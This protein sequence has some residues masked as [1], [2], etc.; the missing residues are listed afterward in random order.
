MNNI[1]PWQTAQWQQLMSQRQQHKLPHALLLSGVAGL[2]KHQFAEHFAESLLCHNNNE[3]GMA[4]GECRGCLLL[5]AGSHPDIKRIEPE[6][7]G[8]AIKVD[9]VRAL[10]N[11]T[12]LSAQFDK[13]YKVVLISPAENMNRAAA[14]SLLKTLEGPADN[15]ILILLTSAPQRLLATIRSRCQRIS[16]VAPHHDV[17]TEWLTAQSITNTQQWLEMADGAP[18]AAF[19]LANNDDNSISAR[20]ES[21]LEL[22]EGLQSRRQDP[23]AMAADWQKKEG[24]RAVKWLTNWVMDIIRLSQGGDTATLACPS[25]RTRLV[26]LAKQLDIDALHQYLTH[27]YESSRLL[28]TTQVNQQLLFEE[29]L[30]RWAALPK[31]RL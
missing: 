29:I 6:E 20:Y 13:G 30:I 7:V 11:F 1:L 25:Q 26:N 27:L 18:I 2:G 15:T 23:L 5:K 28:A 19:N 14:N 10:S 31:N 12:V 22:L 9:Q 8:K 21:G 17:A 16:F 4:C 24:L 3:N